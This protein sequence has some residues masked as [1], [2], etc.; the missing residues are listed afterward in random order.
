MLKLI[1]ERVE[2]SLQSVLATSLKSRLIPYVVQLIEKLS[3]NF[4]IVLIG[5]I[6]RDFLI[7]E[8]LQIEVPKAEDV[9]IV[10]EVSRGQVKTVLSILTE[11][12]EKWRQ[13][14][15]NL[16]VRLRAFNDF[17]TFEIGLGFRRITEFNLDI[18]CARQECYDY[19]GALP[20]VTL[21]VTIEEDIKR[22]DFTVNSIAMLVSPKLY[23]E[24]MIYPEGAL[25]DLRARIL[26]PLH[27][28][29]FV[30]DPTRLLRGIRYSA[31]LGFQLEL[32][33]QD[34]EWRDALRN[35]SRERITEELRLIFGGAYF[36]IPLRIM[37]QLNLLEGSVGI[38]EPSKFPRT[39]E[40]KAVQ[41][42]VRRFIRLMRMWGVDVDSNAIGFGCLKLLDFGLEDLRLTRA[43]SEALEYATNLRASPLKGKE[44]ERA[45]YKLLE[46]K[47]H[48][49]Y[50]GLLNVA[51]TLR[52]CNSDHRFRIRKYLKRFLETERYKAKRLIG[53]E[54]LRSMDYTDP[55]FYSKILRWVRHLQLLGKIRT[56]TQAIKYL[57]YLR[58]KLSTEDL[59]VGRFQ[60]FDIE[61]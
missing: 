49:E 14:Y 44:L 56:R 18:A 41:M 34:E 21:G 47:R 59:S 20:K 54:T 43:E 7:R 2:L 36:K 17:G 40:L 28:R 42:S 45:L 35:L 25:N 19:P 57:K 51:C 32:R 31:K 52:G 22:R 27:P 38:I 50:A 6:P 23:I 48:W 60:S 13:E 46:L 3:D 30:D 26:K 61:L 8:L 39:P 4:R 12:I 33:N 24:E 53:G 10:L 1:R 11:L 9:D 5:G 15:S 16:E 58:G 37:K 29:S 55:K